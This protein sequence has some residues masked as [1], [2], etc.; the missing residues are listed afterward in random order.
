MKPLCAYRFLP[1]L[2]S[3]GPLNLPAQDVAIANARII[4]GNGP[5]IPS[6]TIVVRNGKIVSVAAGV[7]DA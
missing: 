3:L 4:S 1:L 7:A 5:V 6:G 2:L